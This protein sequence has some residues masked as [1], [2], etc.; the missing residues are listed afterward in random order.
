MID[1]GIISR[2]H[3]L[4]SKIE[5]TFEYIDNGM[6]VEETYFDGICRITSQPIN[7]ITERSHNFKWVLEVDNE[8]SITTMKWFKGKA[9]FTA[10]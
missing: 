9:F 10:Q 5:L 7:M 1:I 4:K 6:V 3:I 8:T 2:H